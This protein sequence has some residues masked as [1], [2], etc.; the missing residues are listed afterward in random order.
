ML[1]GGEHARTV[2]A[3]AGIVRARGTRRTGILRREAGTAGDRICGGAIAVL[4][5]ACVGCAKGGG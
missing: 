5:P 3:L 1:Q 4:V 2:A